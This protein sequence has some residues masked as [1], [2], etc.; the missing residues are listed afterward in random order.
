MQVILNQEYNIVKAVKN[1]IIKIKKG[2]ELKGNLESKE[3]ENTFADIRKLSKITYKVNKIKAVW[4]TIKKEQGEEL[5]E[6]PYK[7]FYIYY[8]L[9]SIRIF[10]NQVKR[11]QVSREDALEIVN[12]IM[13]SRLELLKAKI[14]R[15]LYPTPLDFLTTYKFRLVANKKLIKEWKLIYYPSQGYKLLV[16]ALTIKA[17][18]EESALEL[19]TLV[20]LLLP[21]R[22]VKGLNIKILYSSFLFRGKVPKA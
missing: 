3:Q 21:F 12:N 17:K 5:L 6:G 14:L 2:I 1:V 8:I 15:T 19:V 4:D 20:P 18:E 13:L 9:K 11:S 16:L 10:I 7:L 22:E